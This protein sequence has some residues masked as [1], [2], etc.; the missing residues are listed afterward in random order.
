[1]YD[2]VTNEPFYGRGIGFPNVGQNISEWIAVLERLKRVSPELNVIRVY[3]PP[4]CALE[5]EACFTS[6]MKRADELGMYVLVPGTGTTWGYLPIDAGPA[7]KGFG[8]DAQQAYKMGGVLGF[9]QKMLRYFHF[10]N[11]L[12]I[13]IGNEFIQTHHMHAFAGVLKAYARDMKSHMRMCNTD[14]DSL[15]KGQMRRIPLMYAASDDL[16]DPMVQPKA[17]YLFCD[18][19]RA[20][21]D[22][23]GLN[24][25]RWTRDDTGPTE[26][27]R[28]ND[29]VAQKQYPGAFFFSEEG[30]PI[31]SQESGVRS[32]A[33][34]RNFFGDFPAISGY[35]AYTYYGNPN[36][37][38][39]SDKTA[40]AIMTPDGENFF[41]ALAE[42]AKNAVVFQEREPIQPHCPVK[43]RDTA[44]QDY[45]KIVGYSTGDAG[46]ASSCPKPYGEPS[47][48]RDILV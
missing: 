40:N 17:D 2:A 3:E 32:W 15:T 7:P 11:T 5:Q 47:V 46:R 34:A 23:F 9:G 35:A 27:S 6:F 41:A 24:V 36:F 43:L 42:D 37:D 10:P 39:F 30:G 48:A 13:V 18:G 4:A 16:G 26:Y 14:K 12:A 29:W 44:I 38:M 1:M 31:P 20:S 28:I 33:Q 19:R 25:E 8:G 22:I 21:V 45:N